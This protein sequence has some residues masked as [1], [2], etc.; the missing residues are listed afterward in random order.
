MRGGRS[1]SIKELTPLSKPPEINIAA[2]PGDDDVVGEQNI[3][4]NNGRGSWSNMLPELLGEII[5]RVETSDDRWSLRR[6]LPG[7]GDSP[8]QC[9]IKRNKKNSV[10][11]LYLAATPSFTNKGKFIL[12]A[13]RYRHGAHME[14][15]ISLDPDDSSQGSNA[16]VGKLRQLPHNGAKHLSNKSVRQIASKQISPQVPS[17]NFEIGETSYKFNILKSRGP[18][19]MM[20]SLTST[21]TSPDQQFDSVA[22]VKNFQLV[23]TLEPSQPGG[24]GDGETV[25]LQFGKVGDDMF[26]M[27][28]NYK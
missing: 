18:R 11:Y 21:S 5:K 22:S 10:F 25:L 7:L 17:S 16:Y 20:C 14:Y 8:I 24:K 2:V 12:A 27:D 3:G 4:E 19:R 6:N 23:A 9:V 1:N 13:R 28:Y 15:I 26:T